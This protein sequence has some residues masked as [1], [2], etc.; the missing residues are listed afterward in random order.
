[1]ELRDVYEIMSRFEGAALSEMKLEF[2]GLSLSLRKEGEPGRAPFVRKEKPEPISVPASKTGLK[3]VRAPL[4][5][6]F[7]RAK[8]PG[9]EPF[10]KVGD[11]VSKG[12]VIGI[13]E[14]MK[15]MNEITAGVD[16]IVEEVLVKDE[17][18]VEYD[19]VLLKLS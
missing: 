4:V 9:E 18:L 7:Y 11:R 12:D 16:G 17:E 14:A 19:Q 5:G 10:I 3:E 6:I 1:M 15:V 2:Q 13:I 8:A